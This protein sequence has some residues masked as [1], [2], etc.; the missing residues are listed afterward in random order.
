[1][2]VLVPT[3]N[4]ISLLAKGLLFLSRNNTDKSKLPS[5]ENEVGDCQ[6]NEV[7]ILSFTVTL[8][9]PDEEF[10]LFSPE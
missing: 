6:V 8:A 10:I 4:T 2:E 7:S 9:S 1:M 3:V 5:S